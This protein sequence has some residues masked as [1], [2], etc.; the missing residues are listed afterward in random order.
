MKKV[1]A[2]VLMLLLALSGVA[3]AKDIQ[4]FGDGSKRIVDIE[5]SFGVVYHYFDIYEGK[6]TRPD[7][8]DTSNFLRA[9]FSDKTK[10]AHGYDISLADSWDIFLRNAVG[11][12]VPN[13][14]GGKTLYDAFEK[15]NNASNCFRGKYFVESTGSEQ[16]AKAIRQ[17]FASVIHDN[18]DSSLN[19]DSFKELD[20]IKTLGFGGPSFFSLN[21]YG[22]SGTAV[23]GYG[24]LF[25]D[26]NFGYMEDEKNADTGAGDETDINKANG[27]RG[28]KVDTGLPSAVAKQWVFN[29]SSD[30]M[31]GSANLQHT[32]AQSVTNTI[33]Q[34][35]STTK[36]HKAGVDIQMKFKFP[37][38]KSVE[39]T[40]TAKYEYNYSELNS[41]TNGTSGTK[42]NSVT[43][44]Q[45]V[46]DIPIKPH[47]KRLV[48]LLGSD[49][50]VTLGHDFPVAITFKAA[51]FAIFD[52]ESSPVL[53]VW[54]S[55]TDTANGY[56]PQNLT[57]RFSHRD[58]DGYE[59]SH[60]N[61][62]NSIDWKKMSSYTFD[63]YYFINSATYLPYSIT[64]G[65]LS[66][67][68][69]NMGI[70][71]NEPVPMSPLGS[72]SV[73]GGRSFKVPV[74]A[75]F[76]VSANLTIL[77]YDADDQQGKVEYCGFDDLRHGKWVIVDEQ[78]AEAQSELAALSYT[79]DGGAL[80]KTGSKAGK[81]FLEYR[82]DLKNL[83]YYPDPEGDTPQY[84]ADNVTNDTRVEFEIAQ[85]MT[86]F[87]GTVE[88]LSE[89]VAELNGEVDLRDE[90][91]EIVI[92]DKAGSVVER[93]N[94]D[95][96]W[97]VVGGNC[98]EVSV[99]S[100]ILTAAKPGAYK[101]KVNYGG[102]ESGEVPLTVK[103]GVDPTGIELNKTA[104]TLVK[105]EG[106][107]LTAKLQP[108]NAA[109]AVTW[110][111]VDEAVA[112]VD[113][114]G[115]V[116]AVGTGETVIVAK[117]QY[118]GYTALCKVRVETA[119]AGEALSRG[120]IAM[121]K[122]K[123]QKLGTPGGAVG[124]WTVKDENVATV[125]NGKLTARAFGETEL[126]F[127]VESVKQGGEFL[128]KAVA[129]GDR[130]T[131][132]L[133]V[134]K[135]GELVTSV[136]AGT[137]TLVIGVGGEASL[138][139]VVKPAGALDREVFYQSGNKKVAQVDD[140]GRVKGISDGKA[141]ITVTSASG[142][143]AKVTVEVGS[144]VRK[145][146][147]GAKKAT[148]VVGEAYQLSPVS[149]PQVEGFTPTFVSSKPLVAEVSENGLV[150]AVSKGK[151]VITVLHK[152]GSKVKAKFTVTVK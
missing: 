4:I 140:Q 66:F 128:G 53:A 103:E 77:A 115:K 130:I 134:R 75:Q 55:K 42:S 95:L 35:V 107:K 152:P 15:L 151:A 148:L 85:E 59:D 114:D 72:L 13:R 40:V 78:G 65:T 46:S 39:Q 99:R 121:A 135:A 126:Y 11:Y 57:N 69:M 101:L 104:L 47:S 33:T 38:I 52:R 88:V 91:P 6:T 119:Q 146:L 131:V 24:T 20:A 37:I 1:L 122:G 18:V 8:K 61:G 109:S 29:S 14:M 32:F 89:V 9:A 82:P 112:T 48:E 68:G 149:V 86:G 87:D 83:P 12:A 70:R 25:Y 92:R 49:A 110:S 127:D 98:D 71:I 147:L 93:R 34:T 124:V 123:S 90:G 138:A 81:V 133:A 137:K 76:D 105:G 10:K 102:A 145:I 79:P 94:Y 50:Q 58:Q 125:A 44:S 118:G 16:A 21:V 150:T 129:A 142:K 100:N 17:K 45:T 26:F 74:D 31:K 19:A 56:A 41:T 28:V 60:N 141:T 3:S 64:G 54:G 63:N 117:S 36:A 108:Y 62:Y 30:V 136:K 120:K 27:K 67:G 43:Y 144:S 7:T 113:E 73:K 111:S 22:V 2:L 96:K 23:L 51:Q 139:P 97:A 84:G 116:S 143:T 106:E 132:A 80:L 5:D